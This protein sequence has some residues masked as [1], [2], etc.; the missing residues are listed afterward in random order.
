[1]RASYGTAF[2]APTLNER[3]GFAGNPDLGPETS[4]GWEAGIEQV[5]TVDGVVSRIGWGVTY[6][7]NRIRNLITAVKDPATSTFRNRNIAS[8]HIE[9]VESFA[10]F[11]S[12]GGVSVRLN[13]TV[14]RARDGDR[15]RLLRR[16]LRTAALEARWTGAAWSLAARVN[17][18]GPQRDI[19]RDDFSRVTKGGYAL[20]NVSA[21]RRLGDDFAVF[22]R[23]GNL[24]DRD[25]EPADGYAGR[26][27]E[28]HA[29]VEAGW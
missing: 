1:M 25:H 28:F 8:A 4:R 15:R 23:V 11:E 3:F 13:H 18:V 9:G 16:P 22:A 29:G 24:L 14:M 5:L 19:R 26:G 12:A 21:R 6:F 10:F 7:D 2:K 20:V 17:H 27:F